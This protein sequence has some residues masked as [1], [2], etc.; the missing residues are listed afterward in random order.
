MAFSGVMPSWLLLDLC[1]NC[2][3]KVE[4]RDEK[5]GVDCKECGGTLN[6]IEDDKAN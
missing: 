5:P 4:P 1:R 2:G 6:R 3:H